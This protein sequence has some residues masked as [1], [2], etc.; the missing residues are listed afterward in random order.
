MNLKYRC[1][2]YAKYDFFIICI[3]NN[4]LKLLLYMTGMGKV[5]YL[6]GNVRK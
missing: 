6:V 2:T 4:S 3:E 1:E 5:D